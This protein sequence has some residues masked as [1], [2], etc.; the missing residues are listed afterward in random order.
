MASKSHPAPQDNTGTSVLSQVPP[1]IS[2]DSPILASAID[3]HED[4]L[5]VYSV[6]TADPSVDASEQLSIIDSGRRSIVQLNAKRSILGSLLPSAHVTRDQSSLYVF[7]FGS[8]AGVSEGQAAL[9][10]LQLHCLTSQE[11]SFFTPSSLYPCSAACSELPSPCSN[12]PDIVSAD[13]T[14]ASSSGPPL[15][16]KPLR[17][18]F[19][20]FLQAVRDRLVGDICENSKEKANGRTA[21]KLKD[22]FLLSSS[23]A[24]SEWGAGWEHHARTR[25]LIYCHLQLHLSHA[26][27]SSARLIIHPV[28]RPSYYLPLYNMLPLPSGTPMALLP[29]GVPAFYLSTYSGPSTALTTQFEDSLVGLGAG[30]WKRPCAISEQRLKPEHARSGCQ[31]SS[32]TF[33]I[34]WLAVQNKQGEEKG[35]PLIWPARLCI[36]YH[37]ASPSPHARNS[38]SYIPELSA[39]LQA[40]PPP[41]APAI[42]STL[43]S[44]SSGI[45]LSSDVAGPSVTTIAPE[46]QTPEHKA[47]PCALGRRIRALTSSPTSDSLRAFR[48]M[49]L[50]SHPYTRNIHKVA[51]K[52]SGY[53]DSIAKERERERERLKRERESREAAAAVRFIPAST[54]NVVMQTATPSDQP[55]ETTSQSSVQLPGLPSNELP[56]KRAE[57]PPVPQPVQQM[58]NDAGI[59]EPSSSPPQDA[60]ESLFSPPEETIDLPPSDDPHV[61]ED[62]PM[63]SARHPYDP[64]E[65]SSDSQSVHFSADPYIMEPSWMPSSGGFMDNMDYSMSFPMNIDSIGSEPGAGGMTSR[66]NVEDDFNVFTDDDFSFFDGPATSSRGTALAPL[67]E[68]QPVPLSTGFS[69]SSAVTPL[70]LPPLITGEGIHGSGPGPPSQASPWATTSMAE[71][72]TPHGLDVPFGDDIPPP[73]DLLPPSPGRTPSSHSAPATPGVHLADAF[74]LSVCKAREP[75]AGLGIFDPIP[76]A[77]S[78]KLAD[79]KYA[80]GKFAMPSPPDEEDRAEVFLPSSSPARSDGWFSRYTAATDPRFGMVRKLIGVKRKG[81]VQGPRIT[82][83]PSSWQREHE[84]WASSRLSAPPEDSRSE[85]ESEEEEPWVQEEEETAA[86]RSSTPPPSYLPLGP[87]LLQT[88]FHHRYL[89]P[90]STPLRPPGSAVSNPPASIAATS[91]PTPV[92]PAAAVGAASEKSKSLEAAAQMLVREVVEN[93]AWAEAWRANA[94]AS[95]TAGSLPTEVWQTDVKWVSDLL[96]TVETTETPMTL[97][98]LYGFSEEESADGNAR[99]DNHVELLEPPMLALGKS[100]AIVHVL[101]TALRFWEK[102]GLGPRAG[103]KDLVAYMLFEDTTEE[104]QEQL[105]QWMARVSS[106]YSAKGYG[107]HALGIPPKSPTSGLLPVQFD[108]LRKTLVSLVEQLN[109][110]QWQSTVVFYIAAPASVTSLT[111]QVLRYLFSAIKRVTKALPDAQLFFHF[112]PEALASGLLS[113]PRTTHAGLDAF[114]DNVYDRIL[115]PVDRAMSRKLFMHS[116]PTRA[117]LHA[118]AMT[119]ARALPS[120]HP[121][122][123]RGYKQSARTSFL[124]EAHPTSLD[125]LERHTLLH[126]GYHTTPDNRWLLAACVDERGEGH[127]VT[128]WLLPTESTEDFITSQVWNFVHTFARRASVEWRIV[129]SKL[130]AMRNLEAQVWISHLDR[131]VATSSDIPPMHVTLLSVDID[132]S[133][134]FVAPDSSDVSFTKRSRSPTTSQSPVR[135]ARVPPNA[136]FLDVS[137][138][139]YAISP[140]VARTCVPAFGSRQGAQ[141][142]VGYD[143]IPIIPDSE[144]EEPIMQRT[145]CLHARLRSALAHVPTGADFASIDMVQLAQLHTISSPKSSRVKTRT[146]SAREQGMEDLRDITSNFHDLA[147][148]ARLRWKL[149]D[150]GLP[151]HLAALKVMCMALVGDSVDVNG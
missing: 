22:G 50:S 11:T 19:F 112:V 102:L 97:R 61:F 151:F 23:P 147:V 47:L 46:P 30:D 150:T 6:Y 109:P 33:V 122:Q 139:T 115:Q 79:G 123:S 136:V 100:E 116:A 78:H 85:A 133:W 149:P 45:A 96:G 101:P 108:T 39:Q 110:S 10:A 145:P 74:E 17:L 118:P 117:Y 120:G 53:V 88:Y 9:E 129:I 98:S 93:A 86:P 113:D 26:P 35:I 141:S 24:S 20:Q 34:A 99:S 83:T 114:V 69:I 16:R 49:S 25:P 21:V 42:P 64:P 94:I 146:I 70:N 82:R 130:G 66:Y 32:P 31:N 91:V 77:S 105:S 18:P 72:F 104:R 51:G 28:L 143:D 62:V 55:R 119:L 3:L 29:Y 142:L 60:A 73:P 8:T 89:L 58:E 44:I 144:D 43:S 56:P 128:A 76:F 127:E 57:S 107:T 92:S 14:T 13:C 126:V 135:P 1:Q 134:M 131:T 68:V 95:L 15:L 54:S 38:L 125:V 48:T 80:V 111:S 71:G 84:E 103:A 140:A 124:L 137:C 59:E 132:N 7:A 4:P 63:D 138:S 67:P 148:L 81:V 87:T 27:P 75:R 36:T 37:P 2:L 40:S 65:E 5:I 106:A 121:D 12:C 90:L 52:V 41:P